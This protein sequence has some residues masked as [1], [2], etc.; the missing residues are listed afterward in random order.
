[1]TGTIGQLVGGAVWGITLVAGCGCGQTIHRKMAP[2]EIK[3]LTPQDT[4][5][6]P[7]LKLPAITDDAPDQNQYLAKD[8]RITKGSELTSHQ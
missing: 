6:P 2:E 7:V 4:I 5:K 8:I 3:F 1:M